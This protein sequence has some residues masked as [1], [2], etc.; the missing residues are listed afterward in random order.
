MQ[1]KARVSS[2][3]CFNTRLDN[4]ATPPWLY[5]IKLRTYVLFLTFSF[6]LIECVDL[7]GGRWLEGSVGTAVIPS[8]RAFG[9]SVSCFWFSSDSSG[10]FQHYWI[11]YKGFYSSFFFFFL[12]HDRPSFL[13]EEFFKPFPL[14]RSTLV[15]FKST[16]NLPSM[17]SDTATL[18]SIPSTT[19]ISAVCDLKDEDMS[20]LSFLIRW[21]GFS[22]WHV[23]SELKAIA[24]RASEGF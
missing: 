9:L 20:Y 6:E 5:S 12:P 8:G 4:Y 7:T 16:S 10:N 22:A 23:E 21:N 3:V 2:P 19:C 1:K 18:A 24:Q 17:N 11:L 13:T 14:H 15:C